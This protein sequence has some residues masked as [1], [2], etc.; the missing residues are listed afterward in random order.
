V[1]HLTGAK[2][3]AG[4]SLRNA[5][6]VESFRS[7]KSGGARSIRSLRSLKSLPGSLKSSVSVNARG[8][9]DWFKERVVGVGV[10]VDIGV[11]G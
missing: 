2:G 9:R 3:G 1:S 6:S 7:V 8:L 5:P 10:G 11:V 4:I